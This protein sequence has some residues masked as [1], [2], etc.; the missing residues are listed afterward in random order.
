MLRQFWIS[1]IVALLLTSCAGV[2]ENSSDWEG[3]DKKVFRYNQADGLSSLDPAFA[4]NQAN[5]WATT[6]IYSG[7]F[8][9]SDDL[10]TVPNL[11]DTW[12]ISED[13]KVYTFNKIGRASCRE[14]EDN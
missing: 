7:L 2:G 11:V 12:K 13:G 1:I 3:G 6:Q 10:Y 14:R 5:C 8:E 4:R 9:L